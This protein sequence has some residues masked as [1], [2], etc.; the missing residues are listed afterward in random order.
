MVVEDK[1]QLLDD[2]E[3]M[4]DFSFTEADLRVKQV[5]F[6]PSHEA[7]KFSPKL[8]NMALHVTHSLVVV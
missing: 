4:T 5:F 7:S 1:K 6:G 8:T 3:L 2:P